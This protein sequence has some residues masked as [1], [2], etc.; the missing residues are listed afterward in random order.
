VSE[1][2]LDTRDKVREHY[3][4]TAEGKGRSR[5]ADSYGTSGTTST[6]AFIGAL[7]AAGSDQR[8]V[9]QLDEAPLV[10]PGYHV[11]EGNAFSYNTMDC[12]GVADKWR[13]TVIQLWNP[14]DEPNAEFMTARKF[15]AIYAEW[16]QTFPFPTTPRCASSMVT[17]TVQLVSITSGVWRR[18]QYLRLHISR[19]YVNIVT[20][21]RSLTT[22][23]ALC[24]EFFES[25]VN[26]S[27]G[28]SA[29]SQR[30]VEVP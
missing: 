22:I 21:L 1:T 3:A 12:G 2:I 23:S 4:I 27:L 16:P 15:L 20:P 19:F 10:A 28:D 18:V 17:P 8:L 5:A 26:F 30:P 7:R 6:L 24:P 14:G 9:F 13:E 11:T 25:P 29:M